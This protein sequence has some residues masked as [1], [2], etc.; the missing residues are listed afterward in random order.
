MI[1][2]SLCMIVKNEEQVLARCLD[3]LHDLMD[4][5]IIVDTG[6]TDAT[7]EIASHYTD[8]IYHL[9]WTHDF[10]AAR[11]F[12]F[13]KASMDYI[14]TADADEILDAKNWHRFLH[15]KQLLLPEIEIVQMEYVT[16][17]EF[18]T[19]MNFHKEYR[20][21]LFRRLRT[22]EWIDPI[23]ETVRL[24][25]V[26]FDSDIEILHKPVSLHSS[27]DF[28]SFLRIHRNGQALS[29]KLLD[30]Y[31]K[32]L[33]ISGEDP[34]FLAAEP[35]FI[36]S[37]TS[38]NEDYRKAGSC[39]LARIYRL[40]DRRNDFFK[41]CLKDM[42]TTPCS[43]ICCELGTYF[44]QSQD[45]E[46]AI[47]WFYNAVYETSSILDIH[48]SGNIPLFALSECYEKLAFL[49]SDLEQRNTYLE[50]ANSYRQE[51]STWQIP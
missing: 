49:A 47:L 32:E 38:E 3:S 36:D 11:N 35:I 25:P 41:I 40:T 9:P 17:S 21:K 10:S 27:R 16:V 8:Q 15:L 44:A 50:L 51:G 24:D 14:Y 45:Y 20:P 12:A 7:V 6:S 42:L 46:E 33:F 30:M 39:V 28:E 19:V 23:H 34:D 37:L 29:L 13:S 4:E 18:N 31:A 26:V 5:I 48:T 43:E 2:I 1:S 22:F